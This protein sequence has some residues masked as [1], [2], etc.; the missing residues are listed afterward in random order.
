MYD[1]TVDRGPVDTALREAEE[2]VGLDSSNLEVVCTL[3]PFR[4][5]WLNTTAVTPVI[6]LLNLDIETL[7][8]HENDEV[9]YSIW[10]PLR[11]FIVGDYHTQLR[12]L[13]HAK[14][15]LSSEFCFRDP[16]TGLQCII[17]GLTA[18]ICTAVSSIALRELPHFPSYCEAIWK[19]D[20]KMS[21][22]KE[23]APTSNIAKILWTSKL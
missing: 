17:W 18:F 10:V 11:H 19:L 15:A 2:E 7:K 1:R 8:L 3:P 21:Y 9:E 23:L 14:P 12:G 6:A 22:T 13:W 4:S 16:E 20:D 5:G